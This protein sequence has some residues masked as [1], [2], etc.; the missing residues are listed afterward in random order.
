MASEVNALK[1]NL[2]KL[3]VAWDRFLDASL[4]ISAM[5]VVTA[6][7]LTLLDIVSRQFF[8]SAQGWAIEISEYSLVYIAFFGAAWLLREEGHI[9]VELLVEVLSPRHQA[10]L[11]VATSLVGVVVT[12]VLAYFGTTTTIQEYVA[13]TTM[14]ESPLKPPLYPL[15]IPIPIGAA[16]LSIQFMRR[17]YGYYCTWQAEKARRPP[18]QQEVG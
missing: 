4:V 16:S 18:R 5:A 1:A 7:G 15:L 13:G 12:G 8:N 10:L 17:T 11:G 9:K 2:T 14:Y 3:G 6:S